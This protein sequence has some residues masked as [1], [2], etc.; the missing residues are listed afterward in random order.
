MSLKETMK[1]VYG[2]EPEFEEYG[3]PLKNSFMYA[4]RQ[5]RE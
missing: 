5:V 2:Y 4:E 1:A 3:K